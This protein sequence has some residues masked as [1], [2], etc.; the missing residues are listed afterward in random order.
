MPRPI[1]V[2]MK[3]KAHELYNWLLFYSLPV[4]K[5]ILPQQ[6]FENWMALVISIFLLCQD[7]ITEDDITT[8]E[9]LLSFFVKEFGT[10]YNDEG[11]T[12]NF[13]QLLHLGLCVRR[14][15]P[16]WEWSTFCFESMNGT[17]A[18]ISHATKHIGQRN[19][20]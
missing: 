4:L 8:A 6:Y 13:H 7:H 17:I 9:T 19:Y 18:Q 12:Y 1:D 11:Y 2:Y 20:Q 3:Y 14:Y 16:L 10:L 15:G 5:G